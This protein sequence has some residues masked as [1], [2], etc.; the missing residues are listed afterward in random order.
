MS[1][2]GTM[3]VSEEIIYFKGTESLVLEKSEINRII[4]EGALFGKR[5]M[6]YRKSHY[7]PAIIS[8]YSLSFARIAE[9]FKKFS[10][11]LEQ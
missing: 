3:K 2:L 11:P 6:V 4:L 7:Y 10:F 1:F 5:F 8:F 9:T